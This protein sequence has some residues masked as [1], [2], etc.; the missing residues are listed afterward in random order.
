[1]ARLWSLSAC[2]QDYA[3]NVIVVAINCA[4]PFSSHGGPAAAAAAVLRYDK[5]IKSRLTVARSVGPV[6][7]GFVSHARARFAF[8]VRML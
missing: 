4:R 5:Q 3:G 2:T 7:T 8:E 6:C 1:M